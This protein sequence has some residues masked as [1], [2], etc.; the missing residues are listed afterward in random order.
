M[1]Q[2]PRRGYYGVIR[3]VGNTTV[4]VELDALFAGSVSP[5]QQFAWHHLRPMYVR[6]TLVNGISYSFILRSAAEEIA[7]TNL[8]ARTRTPTPD[9]ECDPPRAS[10]PDPEGSKFTHLHHYTCTSVN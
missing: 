6:T 3:D 4:T 8:G 1:N 10:T 2:G 7:R 9:P 5:R